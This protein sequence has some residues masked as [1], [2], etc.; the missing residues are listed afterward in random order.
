MNECST[1]ITQTGLVWDVG[2]SSKKLIQDTTEIIFQLDCRRCIMIKQNVFDSQL[3]FFSDMKRELF[4]FQSCH[5]HL[6][7]GNR[8]IV[9]I[10]VG[11][12]IGDQIHWFRHSIYRSLE[13]WINIIYIYRK[14][15]KFRIWKKRMGSPTNENYI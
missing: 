15:R 11:G 13:Y 10:V 7:F 12:N 3:T 6:C 1:V 5:C 4:L 14:F 2:I 8:W 9:R